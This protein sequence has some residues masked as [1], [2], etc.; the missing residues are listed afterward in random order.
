MMQLLTAI[1]LYM[2]AVARIPAMIRS[3]R[4]TVFIAGFLAGT[5]ALFTV[6]AIYTVVDPALGG[7]NWVKL[8]IHTF[9]VLGLWFLRRAILSAV[10]PET[11]A[12]RRH[13]RAL[14]LYLALVLQTV[15]FIA[16]DVGPT[17]TNFGDSYNIEPAGA[18]F[19]SMVMIFIG[20]ICGE[21]AFRCIQFVP[22]M[23]GAFR[24][25]FSM[26]LIGS[27]AG[28]FSSIELMLDVLSNAA[29]GMASFNIHKSPYYQVLQLV[30]VAFVGLGLSIPA[31]AGRARRRRTARWEREAMVR[32]KPI[33]DKVLAKAGLERVLEA[34]DAAARQDLLHRMIVEIW[35]AE[36]A[37]GKES[38]LT[39]DDR[40]YLLE[41][42]RK[43]DL[44][45]AD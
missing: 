26:V 21:V 20:W 2:L 3:K 27:V 15:F 32:L 43:L 29:P 19:S 34:D 30:P 18:L 5:S 4:D 31:L 38:A 12:G 14:P 40:S 37:S 39:P 9:M 17:T 10:A 35:D 25:G 7:R 22:T 6:P 24:V 44:E 8:G 45:H 13:L 16:T 1:T 11:T 33:R 28:V 41:I 42:E 23:R 36:L